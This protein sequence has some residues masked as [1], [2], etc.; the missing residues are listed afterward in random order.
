MFITRS[1]TAIFTFDLEPPRGGYPQMAAE[2]QS[3]LS[4]SSIKFVFVIK[5]TD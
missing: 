4:G 3:D 1:F 2:H 5:A